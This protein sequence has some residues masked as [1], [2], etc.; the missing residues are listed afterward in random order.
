MKRF[1][2]WF[3]RAVALWLAWSMAYILAALWRTDEPQPSLAQA[4][5]RAL[6][7]GLVLQAGLLWAPSARGRWRIAAALLMIPSGC[8]LLLA[9]AE[10]VQLAMNGNA[11]ELTVALT[12]IV[13]GLV[14]LWQFAS[15]VRATI[16]AASE[17]G[18][19]REA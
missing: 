18:A 10:E 1:S 16:T 15:L 7:V 3:V 13:G 19:R 14:Y 17:S 11:H 9:A 5:V 12:Y 6:L 2:A 8:V 4:L